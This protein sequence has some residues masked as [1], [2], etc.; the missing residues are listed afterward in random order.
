MNKL[1]RIIFNITLIC[2][3]IFSVFNFEVKAADVSNLQSAYNEIVTIN[4][5]QDNSPLGDPFYEI[6]SYTAF[7][8]AINN[9]GGLV[10]IQAVIDDVN[11]LQTD[12]DN[13][14]NSINVAI[15]GLVE[16]DTYNQV[17]NNWN[18]AFQLDLSSYTT[19]SRVLYISELNRIKL[20]IDTPTA[21]QA[22]I[23][24]LDSD[25]SNA[26]NLLELIADKTNLQLVYDNLLLMDLSTY[27]PNS[28]EIFEGE[29]D[30]INLILLSLDTD[31]TLADQT[32]IEANTAINL[33]VLKADKTNLILL[34]DLMIDAYY[35]DINLYTTS[36]H[37]LF[38]EKCDLFGSYIYINQLINDDNVIQSVAD[39]YE[40]KILDALNVLV[41]IEDNTALLEAYILAKN[42]DI[43]NYTLSSQNAYNTE[44]ERLHGIITGRE[45][46]ATNAALALDDLANITSLLIDLP[47]Y[48]F[49]QEAYDNSL[50]IKESDYSVTSY[51]YFSDIQN[52][53]LLLLN[54]MDISQE[55]VDDQ[56]D[57]LEEAINSLK[58][59]IGTIYIK[60]NEEESVNEYISLGLSTITSYSVD[61]N[62]IL[63]IDNNGIIQ[64]I[65]FGE[66][67][68]RIT[69]SDGTVEVINVFVQAKPIVSVY[70]LTISIPFVA[71]GLAAAV[72]YIKKDMWIKLFNTIKKLFIKKEKE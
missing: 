19:S 54:N 63:S 7:T 57:K 25:I 66:T 33:L 48:T 65:S 31:Q 4:S 9:L 51:K 58:A 1:F 72:V 26:S 52:E 50:R 70:I 16:D 14:T 23:L 47:D 27:T 55:V 39:E 11:A 6:N 46:D 42:E 32:L 15:S 2:A 64:G 44:L 29:L 61:N 49:L 30:R 67:N 22:A 18:N 41:H 56:I 20:I 35:R 62:S 3:I 36:S 71:V 68:I 34:N 24:S 12:V 53:T 60:E 38:V 59:K 5:T 13:L 10:G 28:I 69:L 21:G 43:S 17:L 40:V 8:G 37:D 45:L